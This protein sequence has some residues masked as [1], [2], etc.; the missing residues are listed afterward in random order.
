M[1]EPVLMQAIFSFSGHEY[2]VPKG[3]QVPSDDPLA[4]K[5]PR[6][7]VPVS[8]GEPAVRIRVREVE[9]ETAMLN[10]RR[11]A[12]LREARIAQGSKWAAEDDAI[13]EAFKRAVRSD[14]ALELIHDSLTGM[15]TGVRTK[16][17]VIESRRRNVEKAHANALAQ[18]AERAAAAQVE[19]ER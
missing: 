1:K 6:F 2:S 11:A 4:L 9:H 17:D 8:G 10:A 13:V 19:R 5:F 18:E 16:A 7:F 15:V 3:L 14:P 12:E